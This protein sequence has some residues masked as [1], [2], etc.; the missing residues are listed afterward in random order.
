MFVPDAGPEFQET[1]RWGQRGGVSGEGRGRGG[2]EPGPAKKSV[3][4]RAYFGPGRN[5]SATH[6]A[7]ITDLEWREQRRGARLSP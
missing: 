4:G 5:E 6:L 3:A 7:E 1:G 2:A